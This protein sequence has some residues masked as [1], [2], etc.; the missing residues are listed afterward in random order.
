MA[1]KKSARKASAT[2]SPKPPDAIALLTQ[3]HDR[4]RELLSSLENATGARREKL[5]AQ[6]DRELKVHTT[7]EEEIFYPAFIDAAKKKDDKTMYWEALHEHHVV[8]LVMPEMGEGETP[9]D[10]KAK[11][12][13]LKELVE[14]HADEEEED[15]FPRAKQLFDRDELRELGAALQARKEEMMRSGGGAARS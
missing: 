3:D 9:E 7:I 12:K 14:H 11:A 10:L 5:L 2:K 13:V 1:A 15:M 8:D 6:V 4:V